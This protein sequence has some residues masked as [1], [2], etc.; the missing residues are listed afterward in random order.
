MDIISC[1]ELF[2]CEDTVTGNQF[3]IL[4]ACIGGKALRGG[5]VITQTTAGGFLLPLLGITVTIKDDS[6]VL[7]QG[8][9]YKVLQGAVKVS[10]N[11]QFVGK[12]PQFFSHNGIQGNIGTC[13]RLG[14]TQHS[15][16]KLVAGESQ[17][18]G[19]VSVGGVLGDSRQ[20]IHANSH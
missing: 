10:G 3:N 5:A 7:F 16:F 4:G 18:R 6:L 9:A 1:K 8:L 12:L 20:N 13:N 2:L 17:G 11:L 15:Q 19:A 14:G